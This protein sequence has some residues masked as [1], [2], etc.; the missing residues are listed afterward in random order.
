MSDRVVDYVV[1]GAGTAGCTLASRLS[2]DAG[3]TVA[4]LEA[5]GPDTNPAIYAPG[6]DPMFSLWNPGGEENWGYATVPQPGLGGRAIDIARGRVLGGSSA[7]NA[8]IHIRGH[9]RDYDHWASLGNDGWSYDEVL[10]YFRRSETYHGAPSPYR[11][12]RGPL[13]VI[14]YRNP[15]PVGHAFLAAAAELGATEIGN[16][17]NG[18][19]QE[20]GAGFYNSTRTPDGV[21]ATAASA[22][23]T[24]V[25]C[26][27]NLHVISGVRCTR[28]ILDRGRACGVEVVG[29]D[30]PQTVR[31]ER[32]VIVSCGAFESPKLLMLSGIGPADHLRGH[33]LA[34]ARDL[35]GVGA[36][37]QDHL[38]LG[39]AFE[40]LV[41]LDPPEMLAEAG[42]CT[43]TGLRSCDDSPDL[44]FFFGPVQF[45]AP[46][47]V[48]DGPGF[49]FAPIVSQP[50]SRG[51]V[52]LASADPSD[53]AVVDPRYL[54]EDYDVAVFEH[55]I[56]Y[57]R[58]LAA[59]SAFDGRRG[60]ELAPGPDV[61][62]RAG[63]RAYIR[64][65]AGTVWHPV[66]TCRMGHGDDAVVDDHLR[67]HGV[68]G[69]RVVDGSI[70]PRIVNA[71]PNAGI[72]MIAEKAADLILTGDR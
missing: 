47:Y 16:D 58:A 61:T 41:P 32:E 43:F 29:P 35:P 50:A 2:A 45:V 52:T 63:L 20:A 53:R 60:R 40:S 42:L 7:V 49:T 28:V 27:P 25:I 67:V 12:D 14:D 30:G 11:G 18:A 17:L 68:E 22:F 54:S 24:P 13:S 70:M 48:T 26:R 55:G 71:N 21:R 34:V 5:G 46:Q 51:T 10:P 57:A 9:R 36:N 62:D 39:V 59:S 65:S 3:V 15:S 19:Q 33:G 4:L 37:L 6:L 31:A 69:L 64:A 8:M 56:R 1:V 72:M 23:V 66:G 44:Q 38:L